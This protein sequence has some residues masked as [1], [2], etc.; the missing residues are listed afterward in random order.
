MPEA[1]QFQ[2]R[3]AHRKKSPHILALRS[4]RTARHSIVDDWMMLLTCICSTRKRKFEWAP[5]VNRSPSRTVKE[6]LKKTPTISDWLN[7]DTCLVSPQKWPLPVCAAFAP[8]IIPSPY[9]MAN[10][11]MNGRYAT[12]ERALK[13][14]LALLLY[15]MGFSIQKIADGHACTERGVLRMMYAAVENLHDLPARFLSMYHSAIASVRFIGKAWR[16]CPRY[17]NESV[18]RGQKTIRPIH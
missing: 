2:V 14:H 18:F 11:D 3:M 16:I 12:S 1:T 7:S 5:T 15:C 9:E 13:N 10:V 8:R 6:W 4:M 17:T